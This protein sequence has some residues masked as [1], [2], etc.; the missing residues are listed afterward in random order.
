MM[1]W[2][3]SRMLPSLRD[4]EA[5]ADLVY[6]II[7]PPPQIRWPLLC[8]RIGA[9]VWIKHENHTPVGAF[10]LRGGVVYLEERKQRQP[11]IRGVIAATHG[12]HGPSIAFSDGRFDL[13]TVI[14]VPCGNS[15]EKNAAM[16]AQGAEWIQYGDEFQNAFEHATLLSEAHKLHVH[17]APEDRF[18][19][20][21]VFRSHTFA[22]RRCLALALRL[23]VACQNQAVGPGCW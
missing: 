16:R 19:S 9:D 2:Q 7:P 17:G 22:K 14:G 8:E 13:R 11:N 6:N 10:K 4:I 20:S 18:R 3:N 12:N 5:A 15:Q 21:L 1:G 23:A